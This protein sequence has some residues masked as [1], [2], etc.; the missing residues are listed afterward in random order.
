MGE[1]RI[2]LFRITLKYTKTEFGGG[3]AYERL[4]TDW[5]FKL[6]KISCAKICSAESCIGRCLVNI[7]YKYNS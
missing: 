5:S 6:L 2:G 1:G 4:V 7:M 3:E